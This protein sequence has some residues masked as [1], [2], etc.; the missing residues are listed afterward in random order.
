MKGFLGKKRTMTAG[1]A[2]VFQA[3]GM[4]VMLVGVP[5]AAAYEVAVGLGSYAGPE[6]T[7][8]MGDRSQWP[9]VADSSWGPLANLVPIATLDRSQQEAVFNNFKH[10]R[11]IAEVPFPTIRWDSKQPDIAFI[12]SFGLSVPYVFVLYEYTER[13]TYQ[14]QATADAL[15]EAGVIDSMLTRDEILRLKQRFPEKKIIMNTRSWTQDSAHFETV[16]DVLDAVCIEFMP[17]GTP[18]YIAENV[19]PFA[20]WAY[21]NNKVLLLLMPPTPDDY[22]G[23]DTFVKVV[24]RSA[25]A[26]YDANVDILPK[27]WMK[28]E[29]IIFAPSNYSW[30][31]HH[32]GYVP[33]D[34]KNSVLAAVKSL[35]LMRPQL[36]AGPAFPGP[37]IR[38]P[39]AI[40]FLLKKKR[41]D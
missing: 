10:R 13:V 4:I 12:E 40:N 39:Q 9:V 20:V 16:Q 30:A 25:Q 19:A 28:S 14:G 32:L 36:D 17:H 11:A 15:A 21:N 38:L 22:L 5:W 35:M 41:T 18:H 1:R 2:V 8:A 24:T 3:I 34:A 37:E 33:E 7:I 31:P 29:N 26:I 6:A 27:G 23:E